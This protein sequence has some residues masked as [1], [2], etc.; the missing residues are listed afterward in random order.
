MTNR[1]PVLHVRDV[2]PVQA[3]GER[4]GERGEL[5]R[6]P[7]RDGEEVLRRDPLG[8]EEKL[9]VRAVQERQEVLAERLLPPA[10]GRAAAARCGV[11][12]DDPPAGGHVDPADLVPEGARQLAEE[13]RVAAPVRLEVG[14]VGQRDLDLEED[15]A[16][17]G[18]RVRDVLEPEV[19]RAVQDQRPHVVKTTFVASRRR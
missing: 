16:V 2:D 10:A 11:R 19:A 14:A 6:E 17:A 9:R 5:G 8:D 12:G 4:L 18:H 1:L 3:A 13:D 15:L 7:G